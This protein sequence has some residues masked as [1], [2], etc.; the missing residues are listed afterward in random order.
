[1]TPQEE[2]SAALR[3][4]ESRGHNVEMVHLPPS[5]IGRELRVWVDNASHSFEEVLLMARSEGM[6]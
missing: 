5:Y 1:M 2:V 6:T 4:L 3:F